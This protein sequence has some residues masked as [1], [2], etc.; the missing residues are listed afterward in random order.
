MVLFKNKENAAVLPHWETQEDRKREESIAKYE[1]VEKWTHWL[2][3]RDIQGVGLGDLA[4]LVMSDKEWL[5]IC[6]TKV[7]PRSNACGCD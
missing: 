2:D 3:K 6:R 7:P 4:M 1:G 5:M